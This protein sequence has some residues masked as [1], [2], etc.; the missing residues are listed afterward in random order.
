[1]TVALKEP[2]VVQSAPASHSDRT[3]KDTGPVTQAGT[4]AADAPATKRAQK[5]R[6][7][8]N[9][10]TISIVIGV[11]AV[12]IALGVAVPKAAKV[13]WCRVSLAAASRVVCAASVACTA[14]VSA[15][16]AYPVGC[17]QH[18]LLAA[19]LHTPSPRPVPGWH[20]APWMHVPRKCC[21]PAP[22]SVHADTLPVGLTPRP[23]LTRHG[24]PL[25]T[26]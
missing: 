23:Q 20:T 22:L 19:S 10:T 13:S 24:S 2:E 17:Y 1:M 5:A 7:T 4:A 8:R 15:E 6:S 25:P 16:W 3:D 11:V 9:V 14:A 21:S 18:A 12:I 26:V